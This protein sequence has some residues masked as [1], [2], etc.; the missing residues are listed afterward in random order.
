[1]DKKI[2]KKIKKDFPWFIKA[3]NGLFVECGDGWSKLIYGWA[4]EIEK[5]LSKKEKKDLY[6]FQVKEKYGV[7]NIYTNCLNEKN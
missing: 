2:E 5:V 7:L 4:K 1:M 6:I 3:N